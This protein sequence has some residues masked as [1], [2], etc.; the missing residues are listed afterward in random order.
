MQRRKSREEEAHTEEDLW[1]SEKTVGCFLAAG[2]Q[3]L[4]SDR[5]NSGRE[6]PLWDGYMGG[7]SVTGQGKWR[8]E[9]GSWGGNHRRGDERWRRERSEAGGRAPGGPQAPPASG[10]GCRDLFCVTNP[11]GAASLTLG[12]QQRGTLKHGPGGSPVFPAARNQKGMS[13][14]QRD[15]NSRMSA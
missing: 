13:E 12:K 6:A 4:N 11:A 2:F 9:E 3:L 8:D 5:R 1:S 7:R 15:E 10:S 14:H